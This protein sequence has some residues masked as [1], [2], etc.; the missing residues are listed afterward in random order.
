MIQLTKIAAN[1]LCILQ[2]E[3][4]CESLLACITEAVERQPFEFPQTFFP[5]PFYKQEVKAHSSLIM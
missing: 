5:Y 2:A 1:C 4:K 3:D